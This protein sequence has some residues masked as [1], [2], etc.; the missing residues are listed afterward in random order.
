MIDSL[1]HGGL[2]S[3]EF[4]QEESNNM[5]ARSRAHLVDAGEAYLE[6]LRFAAT[7]GLM[8]LAAGVACLVHALI[9][10]LCQRTASRTIGLLG[11]LFADR[12]RVEEIRHRSSE[13]I[14]FALM[15]IMG[16]AMAIVFAASPTPP[17]LKL[18]YVALAFSLPITLLLTN[19]ELEAEK[20]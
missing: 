19:S 20:V 7:V 14:A 12:R 13:A 9:P 17:A 6:H 4:P 3:S 5:I 2:P 1:D 18:F 11:V 10:A 16:S 15:V 8:A